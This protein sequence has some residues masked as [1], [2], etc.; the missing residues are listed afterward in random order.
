MILK[1]QSSNRDSVHISFDNSDGKQQ[2]FA[3]YH[4]TRHTAGTIFQPNNVRNNDEAFCL[5][6][7][8]FI[9]LLPMKLQHRDSQN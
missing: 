7:F 8:N 9:G 1:K 5:E 2:T 3:G 6:E 4:T